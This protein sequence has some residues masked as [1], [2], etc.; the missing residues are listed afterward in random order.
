MPDMTG[1]NMLEQLE[2]IG[3]DIIFT[4]AFDQY[5]I[6]AFRF[7]AVDYLL[8][9]ID[10]D[11]L[12][13]AVH[14]FR[15]R[16]EGAQPQQYEQFNSLF[17]QITLKK[18][19]LPMQ[20]GLMFVNID[21]I[22]RLQSTSNYTTFYL[23]NKK[24]IMVSKT[25]GDFETLLEPHYFYRT[26]NSHIINLAHAEKYLKGEGGT[27]VM[28]DKSEIEVSRRKKEEFLKKLEEVALR[29]I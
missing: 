14:K 4:T 26:H 13:E 22:I 16:R 20:E 7:S 11:E 8:K 17:H 28:S 2:A 9:P 3:F 27:V 25:L 10:M 12:K 6:K 29:K 19:A 18:I 5:A 23:S 15:Q 24:S 1:F 21:D